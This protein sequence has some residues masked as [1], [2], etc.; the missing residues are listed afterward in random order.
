MMRSG[1]RFL[2]SLCAAGILAVACW[3]PS[4]E[5]RA[6]GITVVE[7]EPNNTRATAT[8]L[9]QTSVTISGT[10]N[11]QGD[12]DFFQT[13]FTSG[14]VV[15]AVLSGFV[16][17]FDGRI[18][19]LNSSGQVLAEGVRTTATQSTV[20][21][22]AN[23]TGSTPPGTGFIRVSNDFQDGVAG[24]FAYSVNLTQGVAE[25]EPNDTSGAAQPL[26]LAFPIVGTF[27]ARTGVT[28]D[29]YSFTTS[30]AN[31]TVILSFEYGL[32]TNVIMGIQILDSAGVV[33]AQSLRTTIS[34]SGAAKNPS[35]VVPLANAGNYFVRV[36][37]GGATPTSDITVNYSL[38]FR[39]RTGFFEQ[40]PNQSFREAIAVPLTTG[41]AGISVGGILQSGQDVDVYKVNIPAG[42]MLV[43]DVDG[44]SPVKI[45]DGV[46]SM[47]FQEELGVA[48]A[49]NDNNSTL[50][51]GAS[52]SLVNTDPYI[53]TLPRRGGEI[54][55]AVA[56]RL[57]RGAASGFDYVLKLRLEQP[58]ESEGEPNDTP[59]TARRLQDAVITRGTIGSASDVDHFVVDA[60]AGDVMLVNVT[61]FGL[62]S[63]LDARAILRAPSGALLADASTA[64]FS[65]DPFILIPSLPEDGDYTIQLQRRT[66]TTGSGPSYFYEISVSTT[67]AFQATIGNP[68]IDRSGRVDGFDLA[69]LGRRFG[70]TTGSPLYSANADL[71]ADGSIDGQDLT[72]LATFFGSLLNFSGLT[73]IIADI[74]GDASP[75]FGPAN[76][77]PDLVGL[78]TAFDGQDLSLAAFYAQTIGPNTGGVISI[79]SDAS[80]LTG[81]LGT[82]DSYVAGRNLGSDIEIFFDSSTVRIFSIPDPRTDI[83]PGFVANVGDTLSANFPVGPRPP[84]RPTLILEQPTNPS[85]NLISFTINE[86][87]LGGSVSA[88]AAALA[89]SVTDVEP[90]D[91]LPNQ[92]KVALRTPF[93][94]GSIVSTQRVCSD[95]PRL[96]CQVDGDCGGTC[97]DVD[98]APLDARGVPTALPT[99]QTVYLRTHTGGTKFREWERA[100]D[101]V[102][103]PDNGSLSTGVGRTNDLLDRIFPLGTVPFNQPPFKWF[104]RDMLHNFAFRDGVFD[105]H[106]TQLPPPDIDFYYFLG[107]EGD[108]AIVDLTTADQ[109]ATFDSI[110][111]VFSIPLSISALDPSTPEAL[112]AVT[113]AD[114]TLVAS[115][116]D[117]SPTNKDPRVEF[118]VPR[119]AIYVVRITGSPK[120]TTFPG[121]PVS[122]SVYHESLRPDEVSIPIYTRG[123]YPDRVS[124]LNVQVS[125]DPEVVRMTGV[126]LSRGPRIFSNVNQSTLASA[127]ELVA[128]RVQGIPGRV[129]FAIRAYRDNVLTIRNGLTT[130]GAGC[131]GFS[132]PETPIA[133]LRFRAVG[134][135]STTVTFVPNPTTAGQPLI[136][137]GVEENDNGPIWQPFN[138]YGPGVRITVTPA[139]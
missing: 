46:V 15:R 83:Y 94:V 34:G 8:P 62:G 60:R 125:F 48:F 4:G 101:P 92:G 55:V 36:F 130:S 113:T 11:R 50:P 98:T 44:I 127:V 105:P 132:C 16:N 52:F 45:M 74:R 90:T 32:S 75:F 85:G 78:G 67:P 126:D 57:N 40:E 22:T 76:R 13:N 73:E 124:G 20:T 79:D 96:L 21:V 58:P 84:L 2:V 115:S 43:A 18:Q 35:L 117:K 119:T 63:F 42:M 86:A 7:L 38:F 17:N 107:G 9:L 69:D 104:T 51:P 100:L 12:I 128:E 138:G 97:V 19:L 112:S 30:E 131:V 88:N 56:D 26:N 28:E 111:E 3:L 137:L 70:A 31:S 6:Q 49:S 24:T 33:V 64:P 47:F 110:I 5:A 41:E 61:A 1:N 122:Y 66:G 99:A 10:M 77:P 80:S 71:I 91:R 59:Q 89:L 72:A 139:P 102:N 14:N 54:F 82:P 29:F 129:R 106:V 37:N 114:L 123:P 133:R 121:T 39:L 108:R 25:I 103:N 65:P 136:N 116:D 93:Q 87:V 53:R 81:S 120:Q 109:G 135:G 95:N 134:P 68:D 23:I 118:T 27:P